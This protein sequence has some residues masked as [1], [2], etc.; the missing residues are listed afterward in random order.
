[1]EQPRF[2]SVVLDQAIDKTLD[3]SIPEH[4]LERIQVGVRVLVP[5]KK[6][7]RPGTVFLLKPSAEIPHVHPIADL[8]SDKPLIAP[9]LFALASWMARYYGTSLRKALSLMLPPAVRRGME[10]KK[11]LFVKS[12]L[13]KP[14]LAE[15]CPQK[16]RA[17][18]AILEVI[19][20]HPKGI[21][22]T[23][24]LEK[25]GASRSPIDTLVKEKILSLEHLEID[26][27]PLVGEEYFQTKAKALNGEQAAA[28]EKITSS[29]RDT[30]FETH[31]LHGVTGSGKTEIYLQAIDLALSQRKS[32]LLLVPEIAL[33]SQTVDRLKSRFERRIA[34]LHHRLSDG[35]RR[36]TWHRIHSGEIP[37]VVGARSAL[38]SPLVNLG[39]II[40]DEEHEPSYKQSE[41][42]PCYHAR[43]VTV[44]R[45]K[46]SHATVILGSATPS[47]ESYT[48][49]LNGK[50]T[51]SR[52]T[53]RPGNAFLPKVTIVDMRGKKFNLFSDSLLQEIEKRLKVGEQ[54]LLFLNRRGFH[55]AQSC[56]QCGHTVQCPHCSLSLT[57]HKGEN[58]LAC[59]L[60]NYELTPPPRS[61]PECHNPESLKYKGAGTEQVER[62]LH[63]IFPEIR[64]LRLDGD[65]TRHKGSHEKFFKQF[66]SGKADVLIG[67][68][69][70]A[71][72]LHFPSVT[73]VGV[74]NA[75]ASLQIP[76]F[77][78]SEHV[79]Q[80]LTQV[81]GRSGRGALPGE[82]LI[83]TYLPDNST[84]RHA[85]AQDYETFYREEVEARKLFQY[86]PFSHLIKF[87]FSGLSLSE[88][89]AHAE[90]VRSFLIRHLPAAFE[91]LPV[92]PCGYAKVKD[93]FRFQFL[94]KGDHPHIVTALLPQIPKHS[95][96]RMTLD[97]DPLSTFF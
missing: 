45:G 65:T 13:S 89:Q 40:V 52:L 36:D 78:A 66:R 74:L 12:E 58:T 20:Q 64:T 70:V 71:K 7:L 80:L 14:T 41:E 85:A 47:L 9:D 43:D 76:D 10:E 22:L 57:F 63:A 81:A 28:L 54:S 15:L 95:K 97:V 6:S 82:V 49:A 42:A 56:Q 88:T 4:L 96:V 2:A 79:F 48:N 77:R 34:I 16:P 11:Q 92:T 23:E 51:L 19:L 37:L 3:Y 50:Y 83:Q 17:Q 39:L 94:V 68:Q 61:C 21:L 35:E 72:G 31:L 55:T 30:R 32:A 73:L 25:A 38:F 60:C 69:M 91:L 75:D 8:A 59:H 84:I 44:V 62:A 67:T 29:L 86:P 5:L 93:H 26:R 1:M 33:T 46:L 18:A 90:Q 87:C 27:S 24:L 53:E